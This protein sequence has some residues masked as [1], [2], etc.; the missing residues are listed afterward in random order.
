MIDG[1]ILKRPSSNFNYDTDIDFQVIEWWHSD[2]IYDDDE[3]DEDYMD[4]DTPPKKKYTIRCFGSTDEGESVSCKILNFTPFYYIKVDDDFDKIKMLKMMSYIENSYSMKSFPDALQKK[5][6]TIVNKKDLVGFTNGRIFKFVR[7]VF[8]NYTAMQRSR[9]LFKNP[10]NISGVTKSTKRFKLY[11]SNFEPFLKFCH[12]KDIITAGWIK[13]PFGKYEKTNVSTTQIEVEINWKDVVSMRDTKDIADFLQASWDI[14]VYSHDYSFPDPKEQRNVVYQIAT[15]LEFYK[16]KRH[17]KH[18]LSLK[19]LVIDKP[20]VVVEVFKNEK[21]LI[22]RWCQLISESDPDI[23]YTYN[24]DGFDC[25]YLYERAKIHRIE[26]ELLK[27][28]SR[29]REIPAIIKQEFFSSSAYGDNEYNRYYIPGRLNYDLLIHYKR[30][31]KKYPSYKLDYI[32]NEILKVGKHN[33]TAKDIFKSYES[34]DPDKMA[35]IGSYCINDTSL[36]Q[37]LVN[38]QLI[39]I[40]IIQLANVTYVPI[41]YLTTRGQT[42]K[43]YSQILRKASQMNFLAPHTNFNEDANPISVKLRMPCYELDDYLGKYISIDCG[44]TQTAGRNFVI[45]GK[46]TEIL[47]DDSFVILSDVELTRE[48]FGS[49][50]TFDNGLKLQASRVFPTEELADDSFTG[51]TVLTAQSNI[52]IDNVCVLDFAS[53]YPTCIIS[54]NLC[55]SSIVLDDKYLDIPDVKYETFDWDDKIEYRMKHTCCGIGKSGKSKGQVC[56]K[57]AYFEID[58]LYY[59]RIHDPLKKSRGEDEKFQK[60]DVHYNYIIVQT[61]DE[62]NNKG[63]IPALLEELYAERKSIKKQ[64]AKAKSEGNKLLS[65]IL[66][67]TQLAVKVS[68]K[69]DD[70]SEYTHLYIC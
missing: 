45:N 7:V 20:D 29:S 32:A 69:F 30:G 47:S 18:L 10:I 16:S 11:E 28:L 56:G 36:L 70:K 42:I 55:Y 65:D 6:C 17:V 15:T 48:F 14:E 64:M 51:A 39:L 40:T 8:N 26:R 35:T 66:D 52:H 41:G 63:V 25:V 44:K 53:L 59:C 24:G 46:V 2:D 57:Q 19:H 49:K 67:S 38:H 3:D 21:D 43:V 68:L 23:M 54:R 5:K 22:L 61:D 12:I 1:T 33:V 4:E 37:D 31:M 13:L 58:E 60:K 34:G 27:T 9:Y 62:L 50:V